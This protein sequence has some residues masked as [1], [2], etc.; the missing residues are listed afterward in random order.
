M[1][2]HNAVLCLLVGKPEISGGLEIFVDHKHHSVQT[3][4]PVNK[5]IK[6]AINW[7]FLTRE[8]SRG[9]KGFISLV[10]HTQISIPIRPRVR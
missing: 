5:E 3:V 7:L 1:D 9:S 6:V 2:L 10:I 8:T 4:F